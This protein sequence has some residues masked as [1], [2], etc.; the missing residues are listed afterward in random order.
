MY[1]ITE[2]AEGDDSY[3]RVLFAFIDGEEGGVKSEIGCLLEGDS[4]QPNIAFVLGWIEGDTHGSDCTHKKMVEAKL[5]VGVPGGLFVRPNVRANR[6][7]AAGR[8]GP[9]WENVPRTPGR[10]K[11]ARRSGSGGS[12]RG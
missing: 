6:T 8:L 12:A 4:A 2:E 11:T 7:A 1:A 9:G 3:F 5:R 10:A